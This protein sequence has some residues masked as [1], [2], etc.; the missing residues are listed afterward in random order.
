MTQSE[1]ALL[2]RG[3]SHYYTAMIRDGWILP[4][5]SSKIMTTE[6]MTKVRSGC[7]FCPR[8]SMVSG[9]KQ[10]VSPPTIQWLVNYIDEKVTFHHGNGNLDG[11]QAVKWLGLRDIF[12]ES[13]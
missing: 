10:V 6:F 13:K 1:V 9:L 5:Y 4:S 12:R 8:A 2:I 3:K 7:V 11:Q